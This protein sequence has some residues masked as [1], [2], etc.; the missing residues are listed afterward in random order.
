MLS[1]I[2]PAFNEEKYIGQC[3][4]AVFNLKGISDCEVIV[5]NNASTDRTGEVVKKEFPGVNPVRSKLSK[6][7]APPRSSR[8]SLTGTS[9][10]VKLIEEPQKGLTLAYNRGAREAQG[11]ILVF[12]DADVILPQNH[13]EKIRKIFKKDSKLVALSGPYVYDDFWAK[14]LFNWVIIFFVLPGEIILN[15]LLNIMSGVTSGNLTVRKE[16]FDKVGGFD[17]KIF[18][19]LDADFAKKVRKLGKVRYK[20]SLRVKSSARRLKTEGRMR[21]LLRY[22]A[23]LFWPYFFKRPFS[24]DYKDI[25]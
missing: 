19:G 14:L 4:R 10:G 1:I 5:V 18:Y 13:L 16:A 24:K 15:R 25:R 12:I 3:L 2:I 9:N 11:D 22:S 20:F 6:A 8:K 17:E 21:M 7:T 23:N